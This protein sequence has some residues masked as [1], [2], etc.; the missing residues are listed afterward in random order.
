MLWSYAMSVSM[1][2]LVVPDRS[3]YVVRIGSTVTRPTAL[4]TNAAG[5]VSRI[6]PPTSSAATSVRRP[7][8]SKA[9][10]PE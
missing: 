6:A 10:A 8:S 3:P 4:S 1:K 9:I 7:A 2:R 5:T